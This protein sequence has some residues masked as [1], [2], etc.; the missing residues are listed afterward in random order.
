MSAGAGSVLASGIAAASP[1]R[2][3][4]RGHDLARDVIGHMG[5][6]EYFLLLLLGRRPSR[7]MVLMV[8]ATLVAIAEH[9][10]V[11]S[12]Q[13][14]RMTLAAAPNALQGAVAAGLL[15]CGEVVLGAAA[16]AGE[17]LMEIAADVRDGANLS[18][19]V[20]ARLA[21][22]RQVRRPLPGF[23]HPLHKPEDPRAWRLLDYA[24]E[25]GVASSYVGILKEIHRQL[26]SAYGRKLPLNVS[27][28]IAAVLLDAEFPA[29]AL[30]GVPLIAR[31]GGLVAHLLEEQKRPIGLK[32]ADVG[33]AAVIFDGELPDDARAALPA[34]AK[35]K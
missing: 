30:K 8:D 2:V 4:V 21:K 9:G 15:G 23:G 6:T 25:I 18:G 10:M 3:V 32:L 27:G 31:A 24:G 20:A 14:A 13:A 28:A 7:S 26:L 33:A 22:L 11:P 12:I 29:E 5:F 34:E 19:A 16:S 17:F 1:D 35:S